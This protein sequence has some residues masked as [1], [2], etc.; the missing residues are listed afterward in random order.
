MPN[1][2]PSLSTDDWVFLNAGDRVLVLRPNEPPCC[3]TIDDVS[4]DACIIWVWLDG[5]GRIL[6]TEH[7]A[8]TFRHPY[9]PNEWVRL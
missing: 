4:E 7:D 6:V 1:L 9:R 8:V 3:G 2:G 5:I